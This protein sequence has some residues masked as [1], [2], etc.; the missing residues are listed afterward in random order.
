M[1]VLRGAG[2]ERFAFFSYAH[3]PGM[4]RE[5]NSWLAATGA[6][7]PDG[8]P[9]GTVHAADPAWTLLV[10]AAVILLGWWVAVWSPSARAGREL[11]SVPPAQRPLEQVQE[12]ATTP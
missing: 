6:R 9:L 1:A 5:L 12:E 11:A 3:L 2:V 8:V 10:M 7:F 4:A